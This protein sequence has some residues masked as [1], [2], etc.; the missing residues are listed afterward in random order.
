MNVVQMVFF[1]GM[2]YFGVV[3]S[4]GINGLKVWINTHTYMHACTCTPYSHIPYTHIEH[5]YY[6]LPQ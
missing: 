4:K 2:I 3:P 1:F 6:L 5:I